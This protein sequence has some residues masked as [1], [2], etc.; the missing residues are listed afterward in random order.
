MVSDK[1]KIFLKNKFIDFI[2][3]FFCFRNFRIFKWD[4]IFFSDFFL[5]FL[6][7]P[8]KTA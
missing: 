8:L 6:D 2:S 1:Y 7:F 4:P 3:I 5:C